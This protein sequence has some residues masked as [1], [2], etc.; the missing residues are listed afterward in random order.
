M[1]FVI[2]F[3]NFTY[4][5]SGIK[6]P[7][8]VVLVPVHGSILMPN[9]S[10]SV[11]VSEDY[12]FKIFSNTNEDLFVGIVQPVLDRYGSLDNK[13]NVFSA[14]TLGRIAEVSEIE[15][16]S[17]IVNISGV[18]RF[19]ITDDHEGKDNIR[20]A[21]V[22]YE[23]YIQDLSDTKETKIN[24]KK[25]IKA[26]NNYFAINN[27]APNWKE[28]NKTTDENLITVLSMLCPFHAREKQALLEATNI[29]T[30]SEMIAKF[31]EFSKF[32]GITPSYTKH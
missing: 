21:N 32:D 28:I 17:L 2:G 18:C 19:D 24:R 16:N 30:Q 14:G 9:A 31:I 4:H 25:L 20:F 5:E 3:M 12:F 13:I 29:Q 7:N 23:R 22:T 26:L 15:D 11:P 6:L 27:V 1:F 8:E 10:I